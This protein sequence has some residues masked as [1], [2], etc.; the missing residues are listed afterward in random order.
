MFS[1]IVKIPAGKLRREEKNTV[2]GPG[3][4]HLQVLVTSLAR[5]FTREDSLKPVRMRHNEKNR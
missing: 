1:K 5:C 2:Q 3:P 4:L